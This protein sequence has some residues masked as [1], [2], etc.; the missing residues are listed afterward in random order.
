MARLYDP[1]T[2]GG[3][4]LALAMGNLREAIAEIARLKTSVLAKAYADR[5]GGT[6]DP[7]FTAMIEEFGV[8]SGTVGNQVFGMMDAAGLVYENDEVTA[9]TAKEALLRLDLFA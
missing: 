3:A 5:P 8:A 9:A 1:S 7:V 4:K 2:P 6:G